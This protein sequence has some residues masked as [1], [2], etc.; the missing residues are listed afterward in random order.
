MLGI[1]R[2]GLYYKPRVNHAKQI[3]KNH[4]TKV[5]E[6][7]PIYGEKKVHEQLLEDGIKVSFLNT[8]AR[9]RQE[10]GLQAVLAVK[11]VNT[12]IPIKE[13][14]YKLRGLNIS[15]ANHVWSTDITYIKIAGGMVYMAAM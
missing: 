15:H 13:Y 6:Q 1:N 9:Y 2:S 14:T 3:I 12:T 7:I 11:Q 4:I 5:F 8:V 10:L